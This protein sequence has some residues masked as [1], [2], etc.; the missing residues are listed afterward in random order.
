MACVTSMRAGLLILA[1]LI[2]DS[3]AYLDE[4]RDAARD[5]L[6]DPDPFGRWDAIEKLR[7]KYRTD[8]DDVLHVVD[9]IVECA[10]KDKEHFMRLRC[11]DL[12]IWF[13]PE[14]LARFTHDW[15][16]ALQDDDHVC[17]QRALE[18]LH[19]IPKEA[20]AHEEKIRSSVLADKI[21]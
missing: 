7:A 17:R 1:S 9:K 18:I 19:R 13:E 3:S 14:V 4:A 6:K 10:T 12:L 20:A 8:P 2:T 5:M 16:G 15:V 11:M 21:V